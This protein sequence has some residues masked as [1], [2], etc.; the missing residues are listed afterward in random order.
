M[1][2][3]SVYL[4]LGDGRYF[5]VITVELDGNEVRFGDAGVD[6]LIGRSG[7]I[8]YEESGGESVARPSALIAPTAEEE[9]TRQI[10]GTNGSLEERK[11]V[12][13]ALGRCKVRRYHELPSLEEGLFVHLFPL[14]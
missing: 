6:G 10:H 1:Q 11:E 9:E 2:L 13:E 14:G 8:V 12:I 3:T 5:V 7:F 4:F